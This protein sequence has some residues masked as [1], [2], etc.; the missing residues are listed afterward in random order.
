M[1]AKLRLKVDWVR[2]A[3]RANYSTAAL[4]ALCCISVRQLERDFHRETSQSPEK[5]LN[6][7]RARDGLKLLREGSTVKEAASILGYRY[8]EGFTRDFKKVFGISPS[9]FREIHRCEFLE[10]VASCEVNFT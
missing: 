2:L 3:R 10:P 1:S 7:L 6:G 9:Y 4:A 5:W 8:P